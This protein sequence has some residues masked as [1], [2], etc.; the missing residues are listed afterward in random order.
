MSRQRRSNV[1]DDRSV[2][3]D[4]FGLVLALTVVAI[5]ALALVD[6]SWPPDTVAA[7][8][9]SA[10]TTVLVG[11]TLL[12]AM[13]ASG[14]AR[15][16]QRAADLIVIAVVV[17]YT[18]LLVLDLATDVPAAAA[19][20]ASHPLTLVA[21]SALAPLVVVRR[22]LH[23]RTVTTGT[24][25]GAISAYLL[26]PIAF[27]YAFLGLEALQATPF[28]GHVEPS[29]SFMYFS[30]STITTVGYGDLTAVTPLAR[31]IATS[32]AVTGQVYLVTFVAMLVGLR[33]QHWVTARRAGTAG[34]EAGGGAPTP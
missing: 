13:R 4:R 22:L 10:A 25:L 2:H 5:I 3:L 33:A 15:R 1:F 34:E 28:F 18:I 31:L 23:H 29:T 26:I 6:L 32:E 20:H 17:I 19:S 27:C 8:G 16:W 12:L 24:L 9:A 11:V 30:L 14:L 21:L 7:A